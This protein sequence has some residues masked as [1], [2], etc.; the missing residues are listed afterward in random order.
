MLRLTFAA[1]ALSLLAGC[2]CTDSVRRA[3]EQHI[4]E[5]VNAIRA[6][7]Y[8]HRDYPASLEACVD[9][10]HLDAEALAWIHPLTRDP[11]PYVYVRPPHDAKEI[12]RAHV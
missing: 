3:E 2:R 6:Y 5:L 4:Q 11:S 10:G 12:G 9:A 8:E 1:L 7:R